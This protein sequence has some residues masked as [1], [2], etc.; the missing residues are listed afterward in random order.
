MMYRYVRRNPSDNGRAGKLLRT[1]DKNQPNHRR[2]GTHVT[3]GTVDED[4]GG[5]SEVEKW[6]GKERGWIGDVLTAQF[7]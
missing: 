6:M 2:R 1:P 5:G 7:D 3:S 4:G